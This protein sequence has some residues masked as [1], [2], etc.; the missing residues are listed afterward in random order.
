MLHLHLGS[1]SKSV[2]PHV[3]VNVQPRFEVAKVETR[4]VEPDGF[5][6]PPRVQSFSDYSSN[7]T[8]S[9]DRGRRG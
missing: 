1:G 5:V 8:L 4:A 2:L 6:G 7:P 9:L 3:P